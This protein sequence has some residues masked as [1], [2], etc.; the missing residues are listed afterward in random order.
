MTSV[1]DI[2]ILISQISQLAG[3]EKGDQEDDTFW[4][5]SGAKLLV[6]FDQIVDKPELINSMTPKDYSESNVCPLGAAF[7]ILARISNVNE[8][9]RNYI[10]DTRTTDN[11]EAPAEQKENM[12]S[13][14]ELALSRCCSYIGQLLGDRF[15]Y[16]QKLLLKNVF[17]S[18]NVC[19]LFASDIYMFII[20]IIHPNHK[21]SMCLLVMNMC[22]LAPTESLVKGAALINR[23]KHPVVNFENPKYTRYL[24]F[25]A[26]Q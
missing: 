4:H 2:K 10:W 20:R 8:P 5:E 1:G 25:S 12:I 22:R 15:H 16:V 11:V 7:K 13:F 24:T 18:S 17:S 21:M 9:F 14:Y 23:M 6:F 19:S 3:T 26:Q